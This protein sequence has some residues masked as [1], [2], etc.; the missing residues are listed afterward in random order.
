[1]IG[2]KKI[3]ASFFVVFLILTVTFVHFKNIHKSIS[4]NVI[5]MHI[6]ANSDDFYDQKIKLEIR[7][8][9]LEKY[10]FAAEDIT[11]EIQYIGNN[12][13]KITADVNSWLED[14]GMYYGAKAHLTRDYFPTKNYG[15]LSLPRGEYTAFKVVLGNGQG[16]NWWC[17]MFPPLCFA[18]S[19][20][21]TIDK[22]S[23]EYLKN[24]LTGEEYELV[25]KGGTKL[26][27]KL[28]ELAGGK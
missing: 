1:M 8:K 11:G 28:L 22:K 14:A 21:G 24:N 25:T 16:K 20:V 7:D 2:L 12:L 6:I 9:I 26:K 23:D 19:S 3:T 27:F 4:A 10:S 13:D 15:G 5:R 18:D 17:V